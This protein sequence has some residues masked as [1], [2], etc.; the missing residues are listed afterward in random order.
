MGDFTALPD[1]VFGLSC[2]HTEAS[3]TAFSFQVSVWSQQAERSRPLGHSRFVEAMVDGQRLLLNVQ[4]FVSFFV[5]TKNNKGECKAIDPVPGH[6]K[7]FWWYTPRIPGISRVFQSYVVWD[8][9]TPGSQE[10]QIRMTPS[11][12]TRNKERTTESETCFERSW[13]SWQQRKSSTA[14]LSEHPQVVHLTPEI[15]AHN[16]CL[17]GEANQSSMIPSRLQNSSAV[18]RANKINL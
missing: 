6:L 11:P 8:L 4:T 15:W 16:K 9:G 12:E 17:S 18:F 14:V 3:L 5:Y 10:E 13:K 7:K 2:H 1:G